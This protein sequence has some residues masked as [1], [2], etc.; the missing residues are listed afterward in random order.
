VGER[1]MLMNKS[2]IIL[3]NLPDSKQILGNLDV[4]QKKALDELYSI[5]TETAIEMGQSSNLEDIKRVND[6]FLEKAKKIKNDLV[7]YFKMHLL[8]SDNSFGGETDTL[9]GIADSAKKN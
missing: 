4:E 3:K 7:F 1:V 5:F 9:A 2:K 6:S 8:F